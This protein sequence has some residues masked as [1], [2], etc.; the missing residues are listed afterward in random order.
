[1]QTKSQIGK[2]GEEIAV[3]YLRRNGFLIADTNWRNGRYEIDI[4][5]Q[6]HGMTHFVEVKTRSAGSLTPPEQAL[7][8]SK[9]DAMHRAVNA[10]LAQHKI[11]GEFELD[12]VAIDI[13]PD[14]TSD[15]RFI[16]D[17]AESHW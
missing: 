8:K 2:Q 12:L 17:V 11:V 16:S 14:G 13:F 9:T 4:V 1:M 15:I 7:T 5:A 6:K 10:Y 3:A